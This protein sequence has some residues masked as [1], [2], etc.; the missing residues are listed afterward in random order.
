MPSMD[1]T[2]ER[3]ISGVTLYQPIEEF[4]DL[5]PTMNYTDI[6][7]DECSGLCRMQADFT[8]DQ[9]TGM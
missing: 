3:T 4:L 2:M 8:R 9:N 1:I 7:L 5:D 6:T